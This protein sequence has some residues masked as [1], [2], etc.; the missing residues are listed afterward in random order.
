[1]GRRGTWFAFDRRHHPHLNV[2]W[3]LGALAG[4]NG[5]CLSQCPYVLKSQWPG[6]L[7]NQGAPSSRLEQDGWLSFLSSLGKVVAQ[8]PHFQRQP[9][10]DPH[11]CPPRVGGAQ[12]RAHS[13][14]GREWLSPCLPPAL[15]PDARQRD[16][17]IVQGQPLI[18][19]RLAPS[20]PGNRITPDLQTLLLAASVTATRRPS[21]DASARVEIRSTESQCDLCKV[22]EGMWHL[23]PGPLLE[24][25]TGPCCVQAGPAWRQGW[26][27]AMGNTPSQLLLQQT[28]LHEA[29]AV[30]RKCVFMGGSLKPKFSDSL[31]PDLTFP[32][33]PAALLASSCKESSSLQASPGG[34]LFT[35]YF[36]AQGFPL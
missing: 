9:S 32:G 11:P 26:V 16:I 6:G 5:F 33:K 34:P 3:P 2:V 36:W 28:P 20:C 30:G 17:L 25:L 31:P 27:V 12:R 8:C 35:G 10:P 14:A 7:A 18:S 15:A 4:M 24:S 21:T 13:P 23:L 22:G 29:L 19:G 1:M